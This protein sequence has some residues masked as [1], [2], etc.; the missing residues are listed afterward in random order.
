MCL[1]VIVVEVVVS[2]LFPLFESVFFFIIHP[3]KSL[4]YC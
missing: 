3:Q 1:V 4:E 2:P